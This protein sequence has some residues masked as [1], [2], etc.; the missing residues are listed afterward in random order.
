M[1]NVLSSGANRVGGGHAESDQRSIGVLRKDT[2]LP[3]VAVSMDK[4]AKVVC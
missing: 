4:R 1:L 3:P 2:V